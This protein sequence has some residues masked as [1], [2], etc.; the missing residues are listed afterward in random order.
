MHCRNKQ[1]RKSNGIKSFR[2]ESLRLAQ[3]SAALHQKAAARRS[4]T[5]TCAAQSAALTWAESSGA[6]PFRT[7]MQSWR[8]FGIT[9]SP[10]SRSSPTRSRPLPRGQCRG[11]WRAT[12][13]STRMAGRRVN[14]SHRD[15]HEEFVFRSVLRK[16]SSRN[17][18]CDRAW[19]SA[20]RHKLR[21]TRR[22]R[23]PRSR[24]RGLHTQ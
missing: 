8:D 15:M 7:R 10:V 17:R 21:A 12:H 9:R 22:R 13:T 3:D 20:G 23:S 6:I 1:S 19:P 4:K 11:H 5:P 14:S 16:S 2:G 24:P 18:S